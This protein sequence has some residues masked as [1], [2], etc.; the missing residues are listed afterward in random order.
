MGKIIMLRES[1]FAGVVANYNIFLDNKKIGSIKNAGQAEINISTGN[2][3]LYLKN[4]ILGIGK[5]NILNF[6]TTNTS[7]VKILVKSVM[8]TTSGIK[9][10]LISNTNNIPKENYEKYSILE[11]LN[12]L[13]KKMRFRKKNL[14]QKRKKFW[15]EIKWKL[16]MF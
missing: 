1:N 11:K 13:R 15:R 6:K 14:K 12:E 7:I 2:H 5:S 8:T 16:C 9:L 3:E 10:E 4:A